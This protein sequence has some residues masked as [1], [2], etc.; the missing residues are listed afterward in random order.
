MLRDRIVISYLGSTKV[1]VYV[2]KGCPQGGVLPPLL[3]CLVKDSLL[4]EL[5]DQGYYSQGFSDDLSTLLIGIC[6]TTLCDLMQSALKLV[7]RWCVSKGQKANPDKTKLILFSRKRKNPG[8]HPPK[9]FGKRIHL[10]DFVKHLGVYLEPKMY[11]NMHISTK[12]NKSIATLWQCRRTY[13]ISWGLS[14]KMLH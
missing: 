13:G 10:S 14:P 8:F 6:V 11:W 4:T 7:E 2:T 3:Y 5:N 12:I 1:C 9:F